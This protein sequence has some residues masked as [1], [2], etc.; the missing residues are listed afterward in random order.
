M[1]TQILK[2]WQESPPPS[3]ISADIWDA[4]TDAVGELKEIVWSDPRIVDDAAKAEGLRYLTRLVAGAIP[5]TME[6]WNPDYPTLLKF[7]ST[8]IQYGIPAADALYQWAAVHGDHVYRIRGARG[9]VHMLDVESRHGHFAHV[10]DWQLCDRG[11]DFAV[12]DDGNLEIVLSHTEQPG[13]WVQIPR[14]FGDLILR[15]YFYD[16][17]TETPAQLQISRD[18]A[19]YPAPAMSPAD[20]AIRGQLLIDWL[21][22]LPTFFAEQVNSY[23]A[24]ATNEMAFDSLSIGWADL[25]YGKANYECEPDEALIVSV[26]PPS[27]VYWSIQLYSQ[28]WDARDWNLRQTSINGQQAQRDEDGVFRAVIAHRDPGVANWLDTAG[29]NRGLLSVRYFRAESIP[30]PSIQTVKLAELHHYLPDTHKTISPEQRREILRRRA[31]AVTRC[32]RL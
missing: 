7:L 14:G 19:R 27:A 8:R 21:R 11:S 4:F 25:R 30:V 24:T 28:Y 16:W 26:T 6:A 2:A 15:Q 1:T 3:T 29:H 10:Q 23:Y 18:G 12:D 9:T 5:M 13:N 17:E 31:E 32:G 20:I 22:N